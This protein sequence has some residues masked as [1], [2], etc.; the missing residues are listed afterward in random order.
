[1]KS[2]Q[3]FIVFTY[4]CFQGLTIGHLAKTLALANSD[5]LAEAEVEMKKWGQWAKVQKG[6]EQTRWKEASIR[7]EVFKGA[8]L[9]RKQW[10][11]AR[12]VGLNQDEVE[13]LIENDR[14]KNSVCLNLFDEDDQ[15]VVQPGVAN[16]VH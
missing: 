7:L 3:I 8:V 15:R 12:K 1:M 4:T 14:K 2:I 6:K 16:W 9:N 11:A 10:K 13:K 5:N